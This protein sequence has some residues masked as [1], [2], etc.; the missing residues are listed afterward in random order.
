MPKKQPETGARESQKVMKVHMQCQQGECT[1]SNL[2]DHVEDSL[3]SWA[4]ESNG[5][6]QEIQ[7]D[8]AT[9]LSQTAL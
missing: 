4:S 8:L 9:K 2:E 7:T 1:V 6:H 5:L 3:S